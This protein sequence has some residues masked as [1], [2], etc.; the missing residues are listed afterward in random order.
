MSATVRRIK[1]HFDTEGNMEKRHYPEHYSGTALS[2]HEKFLVL[3]LVINRP[4]ICLHEIRCELLEMT[5]ID[6]SIATICRLLQKCGFTRTKIQAS[7]LQQSEEHRQRYRTEMELYEAEMLVFVD[8]SGADRRRLTE[9]VW[10]QPPGKAHSSS[11]AG[12]ERTTCFCYLCHFKAMCTSVVTIFSV[13]LFLVQ[14]FSSESIYVA[15]T[16]ATG[17]VGRGTGLAHQLTMICS[18]P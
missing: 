6:A 7:A 3:A 10:L 4:R 13:E 2:Q 12:S 17:Y 5:G 15:I 18:Y 8:E 9:K 14:H 1:W 16:I 11:K